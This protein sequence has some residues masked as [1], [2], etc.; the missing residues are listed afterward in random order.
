MRPPSDAKT[1]DPL[2]GYL[3][4]G[5]ALRER[6]WDPVAEHLRDARQVLIVPD[7][8]L[9]LVN[10][11]T[12]PVTDRRYL[13]ETGPRIHYLSAEKDLLR[14]ADGPRGKKGLLALG[15]VDFEARPGAGDTRLP[16][17]SATFR[18]QR[19]A[20]GEFRG[21]RFDALPGSAD[22]AAAVLDLWKEGDESGGAGNEAA[23]L[24]GPRA[25]EAAFS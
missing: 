1:S 24:L 17:A 9:Q 3:D 16:P 15:G 22:E 8:N 6:V 11:S 7:G 18:G 23:L 10:F 2:S 12:L 20:C 14:R 21:V 13:V 4:A 25:T 19:A 5:G